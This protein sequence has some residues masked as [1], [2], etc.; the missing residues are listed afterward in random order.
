MANDPEAQDWLPGLR[1]VPDV[2]AGGALGGLYTAVREAAPVVCVAWDMPFVPA[3][4]I[5]DLAHRLADCDVAIPAS[6]G[7]RGLEP[8]CAGY[9]PGC[10]KPM[11][12]A[13]DRGDLRA[14]AFH[15]EVETC[16]LPLDLVGRFGDPGVTFFN[17][18]T[19]D[20]LDRAEELW[21][22][23]ESSR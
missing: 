2:R 21:R 3:Q 1:V 14:V 12:S 13:L 19:V 23:Q 8:L 18:N 16:I 10:L 4:L 15:D 17:V 9:G 20:D 6:Q 5:R 7:R 11:E 22:Q